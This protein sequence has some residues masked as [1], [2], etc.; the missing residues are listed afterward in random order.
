MKEVG[1]A[2]A[3]TVV[4]YCFGC[5][6]HTVDAINLTKNKKKTGDLPIEMDFATIPSILP[7]IIVMS[8][9]KSHIKHNLLGHI[10]HTHRKMLRKL[11]Q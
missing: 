2:I 11:S 3:V 8:R 10:Q 4:V 7:S 1:S 6:E 9:S 5:Y